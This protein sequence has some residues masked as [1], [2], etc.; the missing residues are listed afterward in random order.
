VRAPAA[1]PRSAAVVAAAVAAGHLLPSVATIPF[2]SRRLIP[3]LSGVSDKPHVALTFDDGPHPT[4]TPAFLDELARLD[5]KATFFLLGSQVAHHPD[6]ARDIVAA[7]H[8]V[9]VHGWR[10]RPHLLR[11]PWRIAAD[12]AAARDAVVAA[13]GAVPT[14]FRPPNGVVSG[15]GLLAAHRLA[16]RPVL[17]TADGR[18]WAAGATAASVFERIAR[19][20]RPGGVLLLHD[21]DVTSAPQSWRAALG[22]LGPL[23]RLAAERNWS[24]GPLREHW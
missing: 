14:V 3:G 22:A 17:W 23:A 19:G 12:V 7:G 10:H 6:V 5:L 21:S 8:E 9:G 15:A 4:S 18:D 24:M 16:L 20:L 1:V 2:V 13:T 11:A